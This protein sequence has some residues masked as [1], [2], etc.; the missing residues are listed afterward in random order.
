M[1]VIEG[2]MT[3]VDMPGPSRIMEAKLRLAINYEACPLDEVRVYDSNGEQITFNDVP[4]VV[5][6]GYAVVIVATVVL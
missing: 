4:A 2:I 6:P 5:S 3:A 1:S